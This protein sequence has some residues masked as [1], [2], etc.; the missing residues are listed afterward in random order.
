MQNN[1]YF[2]RRTTAVRIALRSQFGCFFFFLLCCFA[3]TSVYLLILLAIKLWLIGQTPAIIIH[4]F[5]ISC[6]FLFYFIFFSFFLVVV[7][8]FRLIWIFCS[9]PSQFQYRQSRL[10]CFTSNFNFYCWP[11]CNPLNC[12]VCQLEARFGKMNYELLLP[13]S[14]FFSLHFYCILKHIR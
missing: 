7:W 6:F 3:C 4:L 12:I 1:T 5:D 14:L 13:T 11:R 8:L 2:I 9:T 10:F